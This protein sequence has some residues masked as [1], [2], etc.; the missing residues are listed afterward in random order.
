M[1]HQQHQTLQ[2]SQ[3]LKQAHKGEG[4]PSPFSLPTA[5]GRSPVRSVE[6]VMA[7][8]TLQ[9]VAVKPMLFQHFRFWAPP[10][11][12]IYA[13]S[14]PSKVFRLHFSFSVFFFFMICLEMPSHRASVPQYLRASEVPSTEWPR[15]E[16]RS[17]INFRT[18]K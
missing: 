1:H 5:P 17:E 2:T 7:L 13:L 6:I 16:Y 3:N 4:L 12:N 11:S 14:L 18:N 10:N 8:L 15:R 9:K